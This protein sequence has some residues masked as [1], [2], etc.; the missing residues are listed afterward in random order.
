MAA[1]TKH[2]MRIAGS[3]EGIGEVADAF[4]RFAAE[5]GIDDAVRRPVQ[6]VLDELLSNTVRCG[7][8]P[9]QALTIEVGF[10]LDGE[11]LRVELAD[12]GMPFDPL[13]REAPDTTLD[14]EDR[15]VGGLGILLVRSLVDEI[16]YDSEGGRNRVRLGKRLAG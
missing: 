5:N 12:D 9:G 2:E 7:E 14:L 13:G 16:T 4:E 15:P 6:I 11:M 10:R 8:V 3:P 1:P